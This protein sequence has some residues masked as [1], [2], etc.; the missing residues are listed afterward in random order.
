[1]M[2][3]LK[4]KRLSKAG[5]I[6]VAAAMITTVPLG[7]AGMNTNTA[8]A[9]SGT[10]GGDAG[11]GDTGYWRGLYGAPGSQ[12]AW[13]QF[14][15]RTRG[16]FANVGKLVSQAGNKHGNPNLLT[17]CQNS[18]YIWYYG[19]RSTPNVWY[20]L[21]SYTNNAPWAEHKPSDQE[22]NDFLK[23]GGDN[24]RKGN[25][26]LVCSGSYE[27]LEKDCGSREETRKVEEGKPIKIE[28]IYAKA[29]GVAPVATQEFPKWD[30]NRR[31]AWQE[32]HYA[33]NAKDTTGNYK[34]WYDQNKAKIDKLGK[35]KGKEFDKLKKEINDSYNKLGKNNNFSSPEVNLDKKNSEGFSDG[36]VFTA[37]DK[38]KKSTVQLGTQKRI[39]K[40]TIKCKMKLQSNGTW[41]KQETAQDWRPAA[42][43]YEKGATSNAK[44]ASFVPTKFS[45]ILNANCN[46]KEVDNVFNNS[47][48]GGKR[49]D[50]QVDAALPGSIKTNS[51][52]SSN[53]VPFGNP[54]H[55]NRVLK[56]TA[57]DPLYYEGDE[58][59]ID[60]N[61][62]PPDYQSVIDCVS[63]GAKIP[64]GDYPNNVANKDLDGYHFADKNRFGAQY[65]GDGANYVTDSATLFRD[66]VNNKLRLDQWIPNIR[67]GKGLDTSKLAISPTGTTM[68]LDGKGSPNKKGQFALDANGIK[69]EASVNDKSKT[70]NGSVNTIEAKGLWASD[71]DKPHQLRSVWKYN[72]TGIPYLRVKTINQNGK[73]V[74]IGTETA[75]KDKVV[76]CNMGLN[77]T[78]EKPK[79]EGPK[80]SV[81][82]E[83]PD[84]NSIGGDSFKIDFVRSGTSTK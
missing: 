71:K 66:N 23:W 39:D 77:K 51:Y 64:A 75:Y 27:Q 60:P 18:R 47:G 31:K 42:G 25:T 14:V 83:Y 3:T 49:E 5:N 2:I 17:Q 33:Q 70:A 63:D 19:D 58:C 53:K 68:A 21:G 54:K 4:S 24:W 72:V 56:T 38:E 57:H 81:N 78:F 67:T 73:E 79:Y 43:G 40:R 29:S 82:P 76:H 44:V 34:K 50:K 20:N 6:I 45:Q 37:S 52:N 10:G 69:F 80:T 7:M 61:I 26:V 28:G 13:T 48:V 9:D 35:V 16:Q 30:N 22:M 11:S 74:V 59:P 84:Y 36:A 8:S 65:A 41:K 32:T 55:S 1:M 62:T 15:N 12:Q 46:K